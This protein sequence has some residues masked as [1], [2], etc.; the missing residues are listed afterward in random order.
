MK[1]AAT[2]AASAQT[3]LDTKG[4]VVSGVASLVGC[5]SGG[6]DADRSDVPTR[7]ARRCC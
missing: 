2:L 7:E 5:A 3:C 4:T 6:K 1:L